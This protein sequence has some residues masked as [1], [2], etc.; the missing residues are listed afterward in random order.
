M[1]LKSFN[2][3]ASENAVVLILG[4]MPGEESLRRQQYYA[5]SMNMF[6]DIMGQ[7]FLLLIALCLQ[8]VRPTHLFQEKL[9]LSDGC[10]L[11]L[12]Y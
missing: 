12:K 1:K 3:A 5:H 6:W 11:K 8:R 2:Y 9:S 10:W 7:M 4:S